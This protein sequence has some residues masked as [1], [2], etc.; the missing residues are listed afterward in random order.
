MIPRALYANAAT[1]NGNIWQTAS[2]VG[3]AIG[4][5]LMGFGNISVAYAVSA[6]LV[7]FSFL[8]ILPITNVPVPKNEIKEKLSNSLTAGFRFVFKIK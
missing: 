8:I 4:G 1:W 6:S 5:L 7:T 3:P 2:V